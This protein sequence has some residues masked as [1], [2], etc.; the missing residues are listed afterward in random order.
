MS[1]VFLAQGFLKVFEASQ[2]FHLKAK[3]P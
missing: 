3:S 1:I 2:G